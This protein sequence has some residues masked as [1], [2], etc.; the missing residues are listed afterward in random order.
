MALPEIEEGWYQFRAVFINRK[1]ETDIWNGSHY[2]RDRGD[3]TKRLKMIENEL[4]H[5]EGAKVIQKITYKSKG[6]SNGY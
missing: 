4:K 5:F 3:M 1:D 6:A 2:I